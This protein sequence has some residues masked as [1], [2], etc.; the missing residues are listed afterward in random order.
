MP[1]FETRKSGLKFSIELL[2]GDEISNSEKSGLFNATETFW[3][4]VE[5]VDGEIQKIPLKDSF[6]SLHTNVELEAYTRYSKYL[7]LAG[8]LSW[9][10][11][12][13]RKFGMDQE[14]GASIG[15]R[16]DFVLPNRS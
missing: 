9:V 3:M 11:E 5:T 1:T 12:D 14:N 4:E 8:I 10:G 13:L 7:R 6:N 2:S 16:M 15:M